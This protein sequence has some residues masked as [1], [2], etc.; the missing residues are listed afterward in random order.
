MDLCP[1]LKSTNSR[2]K[3]GNGCSTIVIDIFAY[4]HVHVRQH[5][6]AR[7]Q[8]MQHDVR[9]STPPQDAARLG[10]TGQIIPRPVS[11]KRV[12][13]YTLLGDTLFLSP[14]ICPSPRKI[15]PMDKKSQA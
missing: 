4:I 14:C 12:S 10:V 6:T 9:S 2:S 11:R 3:L 8:T 5:D 13:P 1:R 15:K 7:R